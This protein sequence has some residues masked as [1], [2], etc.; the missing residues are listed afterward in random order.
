MPMTRLMTNVRLTI[1]ATALIAVAVA[2]GGAQQSARAEQKS[3]PP[4]V[5]YALWFA[6]DPALHKELQLTEAQAAKVREIVRLWNVAPAWQRPVPTPLEGV[7]ALEKTFAD[8]LD[9]GQLRRLKQV[10]LQQL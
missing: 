7:K 8:V 6:N 1:V 2:P 4:R 9:A 3:A 10:T 5:N